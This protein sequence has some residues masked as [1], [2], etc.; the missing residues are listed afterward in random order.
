VSVRS[1]P[2]VEIVLAVGLAIIAGCQTRT[3]CDGATGVNDC[4]SVREFEAA[5]GAIRDEQYARAEGILRAITEREP[6]LPG[7]W[8]NLGV[9]QLALGDVV[10]ARGAFE[11]VVELDAAACAAHTALGVLDR[12]Q[13]DF[14]RAESHYRSCIAADPGF[15]L[16][17]L[18]L[19][20]LYE[21]YMGRM[22]EALTAYR[23][24]E[25]LT[26]DTR[27]AGWLVDLERR[28]AREEES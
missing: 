27:V 15:A 28:L 3:V 4:A 9:T 8:L 22:A 11:R 19:G 7:P 12:E 10:A 2:C 23:T 26:S 13:G 14:E 24:Y 18:N 5:I 6:Q 20:I 17:Y 25:S 16:A 1:I 21:L